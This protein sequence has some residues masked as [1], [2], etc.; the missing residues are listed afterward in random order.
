MPQVTIQNLV[1]LNSPDLARIFLI[2]CRRF[3]LFR[4]RTF[5][6]RKLSRS[7]PNFNEKLGCHILVSIRLAFHLRG[8]RN[9]VQ[10]ARTSLPSC[11]TA[12]LRDSPSHL[13]TNPLSHR[14]I[15]QASERSTK[16]SSDRPTE[17]PS[18]RRRDRATDRATERS[19]DRATERPSDRVIPTNTSTKRAG[20]MRGAIK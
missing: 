9:S 19:T 20:G 14:A 5:P 3:E 13:A 2:L 1:P 6:L 18:D 16:R 10:V 12:T 15:D 11:G 4:K 17:R 7:G 8:L